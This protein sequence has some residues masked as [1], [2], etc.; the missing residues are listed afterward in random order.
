MKQI[1]RKAKSLHCPEA[2]DERSSALG[3]KDISFVKKNTFI[4]ILIKTR[5]PILSQD[6]F[7]EQQID[8]FK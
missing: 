1:L 4:D 7:G 2:N 8:F 5:E 6:N 3:Q